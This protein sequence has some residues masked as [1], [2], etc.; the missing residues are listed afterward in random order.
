MPPTSVA[1]LD[2]EKSPQEVVEAAATNTVMPEP[3]R[4]GADSDRRP[5][6]AAQ[7]AAEV[8]RQDWSQLRARAP[9]H[10][11]QAHARIGKAVGQA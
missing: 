7:N 1:G 8:F 3:Q 11:G 9:E 10:T 5:G 6:K 4:E 2:R